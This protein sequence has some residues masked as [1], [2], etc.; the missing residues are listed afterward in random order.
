MSE[1]HILDLVWFLMKS[2]LNVGMGSNMEE[3]WEF[4]D[5]RDKAVSNSFTSMLK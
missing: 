2:K 3:R 4:E 1:V 5:E